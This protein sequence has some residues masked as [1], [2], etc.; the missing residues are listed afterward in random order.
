MRRGAHALA[1]LFVSSVLSSVIVVVTA[2]LQMEKYFENWI[3]Y[4]TTTEAL[5][6]EKI[7]YENNAGEYAT[8]NEVEKNRTLVER[9]EAMLSSENAKF[10]A[11]QQQSRKKQ[12]GQLQP[13]PS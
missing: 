2:F 6:R 12:P 1:A 5:K 13:Q 10:F 11:L 8:L 4:R 3:L 9:V 7:L